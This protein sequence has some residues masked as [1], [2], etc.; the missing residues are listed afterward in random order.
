MPLQLGDIIVVATD[1]LWDN[2]FDQECAQLLAATHARGKSAVDAADA[3]ARYAHAKC[4]PGFPAHVLLNF[5]FAVLAL[6]ASHQHCTAVRAPGC[7]FFP[8]RAALA[9]RDYVGCLQEL[10]FT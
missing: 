9:P 2:M 6:W 3:L 1:G 4:A 10:C 7:V 5:L 8:F